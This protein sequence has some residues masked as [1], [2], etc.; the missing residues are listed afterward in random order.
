MNKCDETWDYLDDF[1]VIGLTETWIDE[2]EWKKIKSK[3]SNSFNWNCTPARRENKKERARGGIITA[4]KKDLQEV[5]V[6]E[7]SPQVVE[8]EMLYN[9]NRWNIITVYSQNI[10]EIMETKRNIYKKRKKSI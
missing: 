2:E 5:K 8:I 10:E 1:D 4:T 6:R 3:M 7:L 9:G